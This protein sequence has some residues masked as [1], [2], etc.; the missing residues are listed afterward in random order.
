MSQGSI[1]A[2]TFA[3]IKMWLVQGRREVD[4]GAWILVGA[5]DLDAELAG[6]AKRP[7]FTSYHNPKHKIHL[8]NQRFALE[9]MP[10]I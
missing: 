3:G 5:Q 7:H 6:L 9:D 4:I 2:D 10:G 8:V 1:I